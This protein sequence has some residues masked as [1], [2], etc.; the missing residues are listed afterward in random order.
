MSSPPP[1]CRLV[2]VAAVDDKGLQGKRL[3]SF[4]HLNDLD[5]YASCIA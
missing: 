3:A 2:A 1:L 5:L 4:L